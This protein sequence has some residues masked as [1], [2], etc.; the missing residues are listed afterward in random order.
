LELVD[1][2]VSENLIPSLASNVSVVSEP[3]EVSFDANGDL[4]DFETAVRSTE[5]K[6]Q[7]VS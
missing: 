4:R 2:A 7:L 6:A 1:L 3:F 5:R